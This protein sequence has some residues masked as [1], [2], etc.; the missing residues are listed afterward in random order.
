MNDVTAADLSN[1]KDVGK[2]S[3]RVGR[4]ETSMAHL[5]RQIVLVLAAQN[6][7]AEHDEIV[8]SVYRAIRFAFKAIGW[9]VPIVGAV[10]TILAVTGQL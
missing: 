8:C 1:S 6:L 2:L 9:T 4:M 7:A 5:D 10:V 3:E